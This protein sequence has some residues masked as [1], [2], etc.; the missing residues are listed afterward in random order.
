MK[1]LMLAL[2]V[3]FAAVA[4]FG[5]TLTPD[6]VNSNNL[7]RIISE[8][9]SA[10]KDKDGDVKI[11]QAGSNFYVIIKPKQKLIRIFNFVKNNGKER[12]ALIVR[13]NN[14]NDKKIFM[15][16]TID[17]DNDAI[18]DYYINY[19]GGLNSENLLDCLD[20]F[21]VLHKEWK[22]MMAE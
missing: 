14:F 9:Y 18:C 21:F 1:K 10:E 11:S 6:E 17:K 3:M 16:V 8:K 5:A 15:R 13:A 19:R 12:A 2:C 4:S 20:W 22:T 7:L